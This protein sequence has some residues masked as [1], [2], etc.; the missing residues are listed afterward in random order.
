M[1][2]FCL[3][4]CSFHVFVTLPQSSLARQRGLKSTAT[5][6]LSCTDEH[7]HIWIELHRPLHSWLGT[8]Q[9]CHGSGALMAQDFTP[10]RKA[11]RLFSTLL[12]LIGDRSL[13][14]YKPR[15]DRNL[16]LP[17]FIKPQAKSKTAAGASSE[18]R[19]SAAIPS[20]E[21]QSVIYSCDH[22]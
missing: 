15:G 14:V 17:R 16:L 19:L 7:G 6:G 11:E 5:S 10:G 3:N 12:C 8:A 13:V 18:P 2:H 1:T 20:E 21:E 9:H 22:G 4:Y